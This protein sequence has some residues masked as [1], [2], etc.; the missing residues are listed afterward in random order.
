MLKGIVEDISSQLVS[1]QPRPLDDVFGVEAHIEQMKSLLEIESDHQVRMIGLWGMGGIGKTTIARCIYEHLGRQFPAHCFI[2]NVDQT[3]KEVNLRFVQQQFLCDILRIRRVDFRTVESG[4][5]L[6]RS[7]LGTLKVFV[8]LDGVEKREQLDALAKE[9][10]WFGPG[11]RIIITTRDKKLL[12][13]CRVTTVHEVQCLENEDSLKMLKHFAFAGRVSPVD[14]YEELAIRASQLAR[15][16]PFAL[17]AFGS[18][19]CGITSLAE[20]EDALHTLETAPHQSIMDVLRSSYN[21]LDLRS[22]AIFLKVACLFNG[23]PISRVSTLLAETETRIKTLADKSLIHISNDGF[24]EMHSLTQQVGREIVLEESMYIARQQK[25]LW[26]S[27][28]AYGILKSKTVSLLKITVCLFHLP[29]M[30]FNFDVCIDHQGT[31]KTEGIALHLC[32]LPHAAS[33]IDGSAFDQMH[34][35]IFLKFFKHLDD[36]ETKLDLIS[37]NYVLPSRLRLLHWDAY[38]LTT[39]PSK[40]PLDCLVELHLRYN[41]LE[42]LWD[43]KPVSY[44]RNCCLIFGVQFNQIWNV[45]IH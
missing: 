37:E 3:C 35:L 43:G 44:Q 4:E 5:K 34:N 45:I 26:G 21:N 38:P 23:E 17:V 29:F 15:G 42:Y 16:L 14:A 28:E 20:W 8:V 2:E 32:E 40:F 24:I 25:L 22:K 18:Y 1:I 36:M 6:V 13:S 19:L 10:S 7:R 11:S 12:D 41:N 9:T 39:L 27:L 31:E 33:S 30:S